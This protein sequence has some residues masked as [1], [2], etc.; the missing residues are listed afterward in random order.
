MNITAK[1]RALLMI[2][3]KDSIVIPKSVLVHKYGF[4]KLRSEGLIKVI[5]IDHLFHASV[6]EKGEA[7]IALSLLQHEK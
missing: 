2:Y 5:K 6:T 4:G 3:Q 7:F 1:L